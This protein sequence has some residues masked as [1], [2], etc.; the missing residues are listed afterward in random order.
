MLF[1]TFCFCKA[2]ITLQGQSNLRKINFALGLKG[3]FGGGGVSKS[4]LAK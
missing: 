4:N 1:V 3:I 2:K